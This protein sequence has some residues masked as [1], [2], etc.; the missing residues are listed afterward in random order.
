MKLVWNKL[1]T[2]WFYLEGKRTYIIATIG[3]LLNLLVVLD[4]TLLTPAEL[5]KI[6]AVLAFLGGAAMRSAINRV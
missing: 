5:V 4:S 6:D 1:I 3:G 2:L